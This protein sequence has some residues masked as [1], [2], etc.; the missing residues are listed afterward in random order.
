[1]SKSVDELLFSG[2]TD[3]ILEIKT[4]MDAEDEY[5]YDM[6]EEYEDYETHEDGTEDDRNSVPMDKFGWFYKV[7]ISTF[8]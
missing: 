5:E 3:P 6:F 2:Y 4:A 8:K 7:H 1:M